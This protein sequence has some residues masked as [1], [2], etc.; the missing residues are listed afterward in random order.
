MEEILSS[1]KMDKIDLEEESERLLKAAYDYEKNI[2][3]FPVRHHSPACSY[4]LKKTINEYMP[5]II[6][7]EGP[8]DSNDLIKYL[9]HE[10]S[11]TPVA[12]YYSYSDKEKVF[13][14]SQGKY[15]CYY[16]FLDY[17]PEYIA[18]KLGKELNIPTEFI[19]LPYPQIL[20]N[21]AAEEESGEAEK[22][23][24]NNDY[25]V[26]R[27]NF[28]HRLCEKSNCRNFSEF[29]EKYYE[30]HG[31]DT[32][33]KSFAKGMLGFCLLSRLGYSEEALLQEGCLQR[34]I[35]MAEKIS[36]AAE[37]YKRVLVIAGGFHIYSLYK[38]SKGYKEKGELVRYHKFKEE[39]IGVYPIRYSFEE[40]DQLSG[41]A[42]G[43]PYPAFYQRVWELIG[44]G[45][46][47]PFEGSV[48]D[49]LIKC[50]K[51]IT[52]KI[53]GYNMSRGLASLR[54]KKEAGVFELL[55]SAKACFVKGELNPSENQ[56]L[57]ELRKE[58][59]GYKIGSIYDSDMIPPILK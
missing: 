30:I 37:K 9:V 51:T 50:G 32:D 54:D 24:Y 3:Y 34:E 45:Q 14:K 15:M 48:M 16:P 57:E 56:V 22:K 8:S 21:T 12:I 44:K 42:S 49:F 25:L 23:A 4:H 36:D 40:S 35:F 46:E 18:L 31:I 38:L 13:S 6:L 11:K 53:E 39:N 2:V 7:I 1:K 43:M 20:L 28:I 58:L 41:Y 55:D 17:S 29:W 47:K 27:S 59:R 26:E 10:D 33:T 52:D 5:E 19:D